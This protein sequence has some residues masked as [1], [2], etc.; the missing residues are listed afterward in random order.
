MLE[1][2]ILIGVLGDIIANV[3]L[4]VMILRGVFRGMD[5]NGV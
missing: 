3:M 1:R 2:I 5:V 4:R